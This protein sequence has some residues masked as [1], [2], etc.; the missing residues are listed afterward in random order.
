MPC[1]E[2]PPVLPPPPLLLLLGRAGS[3][4]TVA[5]RQRGV[6][7]LAEDLEAAIEAGT[8]LQ[9]ME[10]ASLPPR[11]PAGAPA[12][13]VL[14][15]GEPASPCPSLPTSLPACLQGDPREPLLR[16]A[17]V[18]AGQAVTEAAGGAFHPYQLSAYLLLQAE[19]QQREQQLG[20]EESMGVQGGEQAA[21]ALPLLPGRHINRGTLAY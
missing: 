7:R 9:V 19:R 2:L 5:L 8:D 14:S 17:T 18:A 21:A 20:G 15:A 4:L 10:P 3:T 1:C 13:W 6:L 16:A 11:R 12:A